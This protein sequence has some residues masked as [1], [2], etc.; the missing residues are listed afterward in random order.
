[1][2]ASPLRPPEP[3]TG[4]AGL[5]AELVREVERGGYYPAL[6]TDVVE[7]A[8]AGEEV[9]DHLVHLET[10]FDADEVRRHVTVMVLTDSRL[11]VAH[12]DDHPGEEHAAEGPGASPGSVG[13]AGRAASGDPD[14]APATSAAPSV[15]A[16]SVE[17]V[18]L[19]QVGSVVVS[20]RVVDPASH[21][22][23]QPPAELVLTV[24]WG[25][26]RRVD[27]EPATC[28]DPECEADHGYTGTIAGEDVSLRVSA[29]AEGAEAVRSAARFARSL[30]AAALPSPAG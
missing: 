29:D 5:P 30:T 28:G 13:G 4:P 3:P 21:R 2:R 15:A 27:L 1:M 9:R 8:L 6:V 18:P 19:H 22:P 7:L 17:S 14:G 23:G 25:A 16:S 12:V 10:T 24:G 20:H 11:L 26:V